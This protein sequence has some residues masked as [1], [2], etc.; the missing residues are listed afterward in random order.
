MKLFPIFFRQQVASILP[1]VSRFFFNRIYALHSSVLTC[2]GKNEQNTTTIHAVLHLRKNDIL[3]IP[4]TSPC[5]NYMQYG[6]GY[7]V[8]RRPIINTVE[9]IKYRCV[10]PLVWRR[11][12]ISTVEGVQYGEGYAAHHQYGCV[13]SS[14]WWRVC[15]T[16]LSYHQYGGK[17]AVQ[18]YQNCSVGSQWL[19][20]SVTGDPACILKC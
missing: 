15:S 13:T 17:R 18:D 16:D 6:G 19:Y 20:L 4:K 8:W 1:M 12:I 14:L 11:H 9:D 7:S 10:I 5:V 2:F 3:S